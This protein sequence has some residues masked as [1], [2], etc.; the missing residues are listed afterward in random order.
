MTRRKLPCVF[1]ITAALI[2]AAITIGGW[3]QRQPVGGTGRAFLTAIARGCPAAIPTKR[4]PT[5][6]DTARALDRLSYAKI[7]NLIFRDG[8]DRCARGVAR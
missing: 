7:S 3:W 6:A 5:V 4:H 2:L 8:R 1:R